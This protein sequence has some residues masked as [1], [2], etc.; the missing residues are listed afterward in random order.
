MNNIR[1]LYERIFI[2]NI[3]KHYEIRFGQDKGRERADLLLT[4][5]K[6]Q[7]LTN[8]Y[9]YYDFSTQKTINKKVY[10]PKLIS[11]GILNEAEMYNNY[12]KR[13][14]FSYL[15]T[16]FAGMTLQTAYMSESNI[17]MPFYSEEAYNSFMNDFYN[18]RTTIVE[19]SFS[20]NFDKIRFNMNICLYYKENGTNK[21]KCYNESK[22]TDS[23][24]ENLVKFLNGIRI[25]R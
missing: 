5:M 4:E 3:Y 8:A 6:E 21:Q 19:D 12:T 1:M 10:K 14:L 9:D 15:K 13:N 23:I 25:S 2:D 22:Q 17:V 16:G 24:N 7:Y 18:V 11:I 20:W